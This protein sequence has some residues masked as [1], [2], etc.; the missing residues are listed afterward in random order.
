MFEAPPARRPWWRVWLKRSA[1]L[2]LGLLAGAAIGFAVGAGG[3]GDPGRPAASAGGPPPEEGRDRGPAERRA[4]RA[5]QRDLRA[6][7]ISPLADD[8]LAVTLDDAPEA[9]IV[10]DVGTG[11]TLWRQ[12]VREP[13]SIAS[14]TK[15]MTALVVV[16]ELSEPGRRVPIGAEAAG[17]E[18]AGDVT[19]SAIGLEEGMHV[20]VTALFQSML[21]A[22][23]NDAATALAI[24]A[25][26]SEE[27]FVASMNRRAEALRLKCTRFVSAHGFEP[28]NRSCALDLAAITRLAIGERRIREVARRERAVVD[29]P[30]DGGRRYLYTT[31][32]LIEMGY[33]GTIGLKTGYTEQAGRSLAAVVRRDG[34]TFAAVLL[35]SPNPESQARL[36]LNAAFRR[37]GAEDR[38]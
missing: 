1:G 35:D 29:F 31:N 15:I 16:D 5:L 4:A 20:K 38:G 36:L 37:V 3:L 8:P 22:S 11:E 10:I 18:G 7:E 24:Q 2:V 30:A 21:I 12:N 26:G 9:G 23:H 19:G 13:R 27:R 25:A 34:R 33:A 17:A 28:G 6:A 32:P 14:L